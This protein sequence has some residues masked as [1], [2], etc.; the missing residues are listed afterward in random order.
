MVISTCFTVSPCFTMFHHVSTCFNIFSFPA[1]WG[2]DDHFLHRDTNWRCWLAGVIPG[3]DHLENMQL[4]AVGDVPVLNLRHAMELTEACEGPGSQVR[5]PIVTGFSQGKMGD[6]SI[7]HEEISC[8]KHVS[9]NNSDFTFNTGSWYFLFILA[10]KMAWTILW[11]YR[12]ATLVVLIL[13]ISLG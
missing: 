6:F 10:S 11:A 9:I 13:D 5:D 3:Y 2:H 8:Q 4:I 1:K 7:E 12:V